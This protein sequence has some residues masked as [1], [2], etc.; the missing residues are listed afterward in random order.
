MS[1]TYFLT[2]AYVE[3]GVEECADLEQ[4]FHRI[5]SHIS[6]CFG[7]RSAA[8]L[9]PP[10]NQGDLAAIM[11]FDGHTDCAL[12]C[13]KQCHCIRTAGRDMDAL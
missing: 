10:L 7:R 3:R 12:L 11:S 9:S 1:P 6:G 4:V 5:I 8:M 13:V 2:Y